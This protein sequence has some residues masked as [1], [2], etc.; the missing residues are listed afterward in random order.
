MRPVV[1]PAG[2][3]PADLAADDDWIYELSATEADEVRA[4]VAAVERR[5]L[6]ILEIGRDDFPLPVLER[7]LAA[8][9]DELLEGR[10]FF[11]L[12]GLPVDDLTL[13]QKAA[14]FWGIGLRFGR[15]LSQNPRGHMLGHV[16]DFGGD[17]DDPHVRGY[18]T[19]AA[20]NLH[21]DQCDYVALLCVHPSKEG[22]AS[23]I[24]SSVTLY[25]EMLKSC[26]DLVRKL[27][28]EFHFTR[29][30][31]V[32]PGRQP[33][34]RMP[35]FSFHEGYFA[36]RG[37]GAQV[38]KAQGLPGVPKF[39][40]A[41]RA[42]LAAF[43]ETAPQNCFDMEF[44][45]GDIQILHNHVTLHTRTAFVD[46]PEP[47]RKRHLMRLWLGD[48]DGR[49]LVPGFRKNISGIVVEGTVPC[50]PVNSFAPA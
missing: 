38:M 9:K 46:W 6:D 31:E 35:I 10:G 37:A 39:T 11:L 25:N 33:W 16:K 21:S 8:L 4:A 12:R 32:P 50:A 47:E 14:A 18:Q 36:T 24:A 20:M 1:D 43:R 44:R 40:D 17:Y 42:A 29:H 45:P 22:G 7:G 13:A 28:A 30:G 3:Y 27:T 19:S 48:R 2:W 23:R 49:P 5:G 26:P 15:P 34:Y 41:Q